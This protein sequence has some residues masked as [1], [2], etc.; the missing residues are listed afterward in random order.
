M[1]QLLAIIALI[2]ATAVGANAQSIRL[3][4]AIPAL[5]VTTNLDETLAMYNRDYTCLIFAHSE[6]K[7]CVDA[8]SN[9]SSTAERLNSQ[10]A[11]VIITGEAE[12]NSA[13]ITE[14]LSAENYILAFDDNNNTLK[15]FGINYVPFVVIYRNKNS[16]VKWFGPIH[17]LNDDIIKQLK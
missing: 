10:C 6:S 4:E 12:E 1:R 14:R 13:E 3:D 9:F 5:S 15:A 16:R 8:M 2:C 7:P 11:I 17:H